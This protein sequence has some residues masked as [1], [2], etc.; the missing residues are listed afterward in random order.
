MSF[1]CIVGGQRDR[2]RDGERGLACVHPQELQEKHEAQEREV[3]VRI[4][5]EKQYE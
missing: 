5:V 3:A 1:W 4:A 2:D